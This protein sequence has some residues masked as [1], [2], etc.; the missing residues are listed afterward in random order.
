MSEAPPTSQPEQGSKPSGNNQGNSG[1]KKHHHKSKGRGNY[2]NSANKLSGSSF[3]GATAELSG[4][5]FLCHSEM[6]KKSFQLKDT[7]DAI[8]VWTMTEFKKHS[9]HART[10]FEDEEDPVVVKPSL[11]NDFG[12]DFS[13]ERAQF[14]IDKDKKSF[15]NAC[16]D[17][18]DP[19]DTLG[20]TEDIKTWRIPG[21]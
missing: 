15:D 8:K 12:Y 9:Q 20:F 18:V 16:A 6:E 5:V 13:A 17:K 3:K 19:A 10:I 21:T 4:H 14:A 2:A 11:E 1:K 7:I